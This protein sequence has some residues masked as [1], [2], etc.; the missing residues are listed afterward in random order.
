MTVATHDIWGHTVFKAQSLLEYWPLSRDSS[1]LST[2]LHLFFQQV[3]S[4][5]SCWWFMTLPST[6]G[7]LG[8]QGHSEGSCE[9]VAYKVPRCCALCRKAE[10]SLWQ[11]QQQQQQRR[12]DWEWSNWTA[13][14][15]SMKNSI[16]MKM[17]WSFD[18]VSFN[19]SCNSLC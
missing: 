17:L 13:L 11:R 2:M 16:A 1:R 12:L 3:T 7:Q 14:G 10:F 5:K 9:D 8:I 4:H 15:S 19:G 6:W 18:W